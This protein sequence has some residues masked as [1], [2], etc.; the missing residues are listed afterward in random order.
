ME[1][2]QIEDRAIKKDTFVQFLKKLN[3][4]NGRKPL[5]I[6][7]DNLLV[8]KTREVFDVYWDLKMYPIFNIAYSPEF[9]PI[10][11]V[12]SQMKRHFKKARLSKLANN[13]DFET[14]QAIHDA[15]D[16][17]RPE[18]IDPCIR[19]SLKLLETFNA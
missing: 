10:E 2:I 8:H 4:I 3:Q 18:K 16:S 6:F 12:F 13:E 9:N 5:A 14:E 15:F 19:K 17:V 1:A 11:S 7:M